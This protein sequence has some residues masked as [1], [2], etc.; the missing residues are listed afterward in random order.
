MRIVYEVSEKNRDGKRIERAEK[1]ERRK[2]RKAKQ[3]A[4]EFA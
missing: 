1:L 2:A 3:F 4:R